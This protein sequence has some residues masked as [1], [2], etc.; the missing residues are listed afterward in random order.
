M[1]SVTAPTRL[2]K[3]P[4]EEFILGVAASLPKERSK[5]PSLLSNQAHVEQ[6]RCT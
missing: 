6:I 2:K 4:F 1:G 3:W 5:P